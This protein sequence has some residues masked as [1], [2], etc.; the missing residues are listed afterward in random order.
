MRKGY[1]GAMRHRL[2]LYEEVLIADGHGGYQ[3]TWQPLADNGDVYAAIYDSA[4]ER[5]VEAG[6]LKT[7]S[8]HRIVIA[9]RQDIVAGMKMTGNS[10]TY[11]IEAALDVDNKKEYLEI[12][13]RSE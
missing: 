8:R 3:K 10:K 4:A 1:L 13:A 7:V 9:Y 6:Q 5:G 11:L 12:Q 2:T